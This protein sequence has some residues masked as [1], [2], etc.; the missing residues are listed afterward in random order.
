MFIPKEYFLA[1]ELFNKAGI[2][3]ANSSMLAKEIESKNIKNTVI[4]M[5]NCIFFNK[6]SRALPN[7]IRNYVEAFKDLNTFE[8]KVLVSALRTELDDIG[9][10]AL[11]KGFKNN[12]YEIKEEI[13]Q[14]K[15][16]A[17]FPNELVEK[18]KDK[19]WYILDE[20]EYHDCLDRG[21]IDGG[22][23]LKKDKY[24]VWY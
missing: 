21:N 20:F 14:G 11:I 17:V 15:R 12:N 7:N 23:K 2:H 10:T 16:F 4:K 18:L 1:N 6:N 8:N 19:T 5:G 9:Y 22:I 3:I 13:I 24:F